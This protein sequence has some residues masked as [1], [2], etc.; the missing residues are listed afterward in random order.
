MV[1]IQLKEK[2]ENCDNLEVE[3]VSLKRDLEKSIA[4]LNRI[5]KFEKSSKTLDHII[6]CQRSPFIKMGL[7][8][9]KNYITTQEDP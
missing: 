4:Q 7:G 9:K 5:L 3:L 1:R 6:N 2:E 8:Y